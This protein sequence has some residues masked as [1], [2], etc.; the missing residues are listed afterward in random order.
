MAEC[1]NCGEEFSD[2]RKELGYDLC[3]SCGDDI[4]HEQAVAKS[5]RVGLNYNK[6]QYQYITDGTDLRT[7]GKKI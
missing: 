7:L 2:K 5:K 3:L 4:A 6:G 1:A